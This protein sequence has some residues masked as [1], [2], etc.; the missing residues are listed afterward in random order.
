METLLEYIKQKKP[1]IIEACRCP[2]RDK[3]YTQNCFINKHVDM[4]N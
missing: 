2:L 3:Q 1:D 4:G